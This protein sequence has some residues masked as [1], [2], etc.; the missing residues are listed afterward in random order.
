MST[1]CNVSVTTSSDRADKE[2]RVTVT[3][4][5][6]VFNTPVRT[7]SLLLPDFDSTAVQNGDY[8]R[9]SSPAAAHR[10]L[11]LAQSLPV[12]AKN[13]R[14]S[15]GVVCGT[16]N[17]GAQQQS[18]CV[19]DNRVYSPDGITC[20]RFSHDD[21]SCDETVTSCFH[22]SSS[23]V[24]PQLTAETYVFQRFTRIEIS[25]LQISMFTRACRCGAISNTS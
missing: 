2:P 4:S 7:T 24:S 8:L 20:S 25:C 3:S 13:S 15:V 14:Q 16:Q 10:R 11:N 18:T 23:T 22:R 5:K 9:K 19:F 21:D 1:N 12:D 17:G 6:D